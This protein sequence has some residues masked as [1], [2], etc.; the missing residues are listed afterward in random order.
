MIEMKV[1]AISD[2]SLMFNPKII[3]GNHTIGNSFFF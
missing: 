2:V 3:F 1:S